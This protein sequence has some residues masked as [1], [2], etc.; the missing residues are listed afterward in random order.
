MPKCPSTTIAVRVTSENLI[1]SY[2]LFKAVLA[3][4]I[5]KT[6][7][8]VVVKLV[9]NKRSIVLQRPTEFIHKICFLNITHTTCTRWQ[10]LVDSV[11]IWTSQI[12]AI[13]AHSKCNNS[14]QFKIAYKCFFKPIHVHTQ[15]VT[16]G[17]YK[18][19]KLVSFPICNYL[20]ITELLAELPRYCSA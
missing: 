15:L 16:L 3:I 20:N 14:F 8:K 4:A 13:V 11:K 7:S 18:I 5:L 6:I 12:F 19:P 9:S 10:P 1:S 2:S 17:M